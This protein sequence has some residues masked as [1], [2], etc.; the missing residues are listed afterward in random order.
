[1]ENNKNK[2]L[3][4][5]PDHNL[6]TGRLFMFMYNELYSIYEFNGKYDHKKLLKEISS[7]FPEARELFRYE[8]EYAEKTEEEVDETEEFRDIMTN[9]DT[10]YII[11]LE[12]MVLCNL[13]RNDIS[14]YYRKPID[15]RRY[16]EIIRT[17]VKKSE[18][19]STFNLIV[20][21]SYG[22]S[23]LDVEEFDIRKQ[24]ISISDNYNND[25]QPVNERII[26]FLQEDKKS[27]LIVLHGKH[28]TGKTSYI[29]YLISH[30]EK[31]FIYLP[32]YLAN[33]ISSPHF[34]PFIKD[35]KNC[36]LIIED[37]EEVIKSRKAGNT[38]GAIENLLNMGDGLLSDA[39]F[40]KVI[41]TF[42]TDLKNIDQAL[43]RK[44][45]LRGLYE[46]KEL[47]T[48]KVQNLFIKN[49]IQHCEPKPMTLAEIY[50]ISDGLTDESLELNKIG[51]EVN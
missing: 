13:C 40:L 35:Y 17:C 41:C 50:N 12:K 8:T 16:M 37:C 21:S 48:V 26:N 2:N 36:I 28:G 39:L 19:K 10:N 6:N 18:K 33:E 4:Q 5:L 9:H 15:I 34:I 1:M 27:G 44:G 24:D 22:G 42:N 14:I 20:N 38:S 51:F 43:L 45:R 47:D 3:Y 31:K 23:S 25:F 46:F 49:N 11:E 7:H 32:S 29:R 30:V